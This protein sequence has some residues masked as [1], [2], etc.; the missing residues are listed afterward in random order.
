[1]ELALTPDP[2][3]L[4]ADE[5]GGVRITGTRFL[6]DVFW[7]VYQSGMTPERMAAEYD[8]LDLPTIH[9]VIGYCLR[10][11][12]EV[13][14]YLARRD[15]EAEEV[16]RTVEARQGKQPPREVWLARLAA[17]RGG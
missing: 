7:P 9:A 16:R 5:Y 17:K 13:E 1:M 6:L 4:Y 12:P 10:R 11:R 8:T 15:A 2:P 14:A 3:P